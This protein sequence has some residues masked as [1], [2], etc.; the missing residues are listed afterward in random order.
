MFLQKIENIHNV[1]Y[2][3]E[4]T[5]LK[6]NFNFISG[7]HTNSNIAFYYFNTETHT[8]SAF[9][10]NR[11]KNQFKKLT[12]ISDDSGRAYIRSLKIVNFY[13]WKLKCNHVMAFPRKCIASHVLRLSS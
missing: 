3:R 12:K 4:K 2:I 5:P 6:C 13:Y 7:C 11:Y 8:I 9:K 10:Q 1:Y